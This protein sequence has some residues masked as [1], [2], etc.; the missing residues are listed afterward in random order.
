[1]GIRWFHIYA[2]YLENL[3]WKLNPFYLLAFKDSLLL[4]MLGGSTLFSG[5]FKAKEEHLY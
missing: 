3:F 4:I 5:K 2:Q 1:M